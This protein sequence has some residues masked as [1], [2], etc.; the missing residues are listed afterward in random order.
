MTGRVSFGNVYTMYTDCALLLLLYASSNV[1]NL[2]ISLWRVEL[3]LPEKKTKFLHR[4]HPLGLFDC[5]HPPTTFRTNIYI[6]PV[7]SDFSF[8]VSYARVFAT[9]KT[10]VLVNY[11]VSFLFIIIIIK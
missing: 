9:G 1:R 8:G 10:N 7:W 5:T 6:F 3:F 11:T 4:Y 2:T